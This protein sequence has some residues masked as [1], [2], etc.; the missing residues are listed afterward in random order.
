MI[1]NYRRRYLSAISLARRIDPIFPYHMPHYLTVPSNHSSMRS[2][3]CGSSKRN[4]QF[5]CSVVDFDDVIV[6]IGPAQAL[7]ELTECMMVRRSPWMIIPRFS[8]PCVFSH[9]L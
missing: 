5:P 6:Q 1:I 3:C 8:L 7:H 4:G 2:V 9:Q